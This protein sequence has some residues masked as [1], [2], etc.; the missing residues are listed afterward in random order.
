VIINKDASADADIR[1]ATQAKAARVLR[2]NAPSLD[3]K[4]DVTLGGAAVASDGTW[5]GQRESVPIRDGVCQMH[6][7]AASAAIVTL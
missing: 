6:V 3:S 7:S 4:A 1:I 2:L 5:R